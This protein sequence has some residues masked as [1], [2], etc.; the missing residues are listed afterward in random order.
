MVPVLAGLLLAGCS[1][2][3]KFIQETDT[4]GVVVYPYKGNN[5]LVSTFRGDA[6]DLMQKKCPKGYTVLR[7]GQTTGL[8]RIQDNV[9]GSEMIELKRWAIKFAC[10]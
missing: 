5:S 10:K 8:R 7:E 2:G 3:V 6:L 1:E 4:G 9:G